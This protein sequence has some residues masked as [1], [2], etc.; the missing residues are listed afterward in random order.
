MWWHWHKVF[1]DIYPLPFLFK[2]LLHGQKDCVSFSGHLNVYSKSAL[3]H[4]GQHGT[5]KY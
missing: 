4:L 2:A 5:F 3:E 1:P